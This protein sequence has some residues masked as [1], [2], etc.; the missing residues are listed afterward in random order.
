MRAG[1]APPQCGHVTPSGQRAASNHGVF[2]VKSGFGQIGVHRNP[3]DIRE[4]KRMVSA[5]LTEQC[6]K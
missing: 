4:H 2:V 3:L 1:R 6:R 5:L